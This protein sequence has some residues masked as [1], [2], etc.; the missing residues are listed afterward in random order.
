MTPGRPLELYL[1]GPEVASP[2]HRQARPRLPPQRDWP[3]P[4][5]RGA[6]PMSRLACVFERGSSWDGCRRPGSSPE[7]QGQPPA[8]GLFGA[9]QVGF[10]P[11]PALCGVQSPALRLLPQ[12]D[13]SWR[14]RL[15]SWGRRAHRSHRHS[16]PFLPCPPAPLPW[17]PQEWAETAP[18]WPEAREE[19]KI[20]PEHVRRE[21]GPR[22]RGAG[23]V[24][25]ACP[26]R[27]LWVAI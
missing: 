5:H 12:Q 1:Q 18:K 8:A 26:G 20:A 9:L 25:Q 16:A 4:P 27:P 15:D 6:Q 7:G 17:V 11:L 24:G 23:E 21:A 14:K 22:C 10:P 2:A 3:H 13:S 19:G